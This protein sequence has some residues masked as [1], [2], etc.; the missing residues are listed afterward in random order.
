[1][2]QEPTKSALLHLY[3]YLK[4]DPRPVLVAVWWISFMQGTTLTPIT[5]SGTHLISSNSRETTKCININGGL[6][7]VVLVPRRDFQPLKWLTWETARRRGPAASVCHFARDPWWWWQPTP[8]IHVK[9]SPC[10]QMNRPCGQP[11]CTSATQ[12]LS[13]LGSIS[14]YVLSSKE[15]CTLG[16]YFARL[17]VLTVKDVMCSYASV[18]VKSRRIIKASTF[19]V[20]LNPESAPGRIICPN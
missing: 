11:V 6:I 14:C 19:D 8:I 20:M 2:V 7:E 9:M 18:K 1:M 10:W 4:S 16:P 12:G 5:H 3:L 13:I 15:F 17:C